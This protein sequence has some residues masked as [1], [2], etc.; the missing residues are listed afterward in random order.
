MVARGDAL[1]WFP[2]R[3]G[4][5]DE[6]DGEFDDAIT[7]PLPTGRDRAPGGVPDPSLGLAFADLDG[8]GLPDLVRVQR[9][10]V[11]YWPSLG[12]GRFGERMAMSGAAELGQLADFDHRRVRW[13]DLDGSGTLDLVYLRHG[14]V[15]MWPNLGGRRF[16]PLQRL[17]GLPQFDARTAMITDVAGEGWLVLVWTTPD[18]GRGTTPSY[19]PLALAI[20][21]GTVTAIDDG[22]GRHRRGK[23]A[24]T[25]CAMP[26]KACRGRP[27]CRAIARWS[28][29]ASS[30]ISSAPRR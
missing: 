30:A 23:L 24:T 27:G 3:T 1:V 26:Q 9:G 10:S 18:L 16:G 28:M 12:N 14:E 22:C 21:P 7:V 13:V 20:A 17:H 4:P 2:S 25:T 15:W 6:R 11:E 5:L 8:D 19:V 29:P